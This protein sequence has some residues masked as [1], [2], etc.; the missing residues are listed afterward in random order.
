LEIRPTE[1]VPL[2]SRHLQRIRLVVFD[3][4]GTTIDFGSRAPV[5]AFV[6]T[7]AGHGVTV[8]EAEARVPMGLPKRDHLIAMLTLPDVAR[9]WREVHGRDWNDADLE[10]LYQRFMPCQL[11]V[12]PCHERLVPGV[13][14]CVARLQRRGVR[15]GATT[16]YFRA[17]AE[18]VREAALRQGFAPEVS[19]CVDDVPA[20]RPA[21]WMVFRVMETLGIYPPGEVVKVGDTVPDVE[22]GLAAGAWSV[23]VTHGSNE[24]GLGEEEF[25]RLSTER[26]QELLDAVRRKLLAAGAHAVIETLADLPELLARLDE[27]LGRGERP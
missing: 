17:A 5:A 16:G 19:V 3:W 21:P 23:A 9:R 6:A 22:E 27:R 8:T 7:F 10:A 24:V 20:G 1:A 11:E 15:I 14:E 12:L 25:E 18:R 4:V 2:G 13:L 26:R